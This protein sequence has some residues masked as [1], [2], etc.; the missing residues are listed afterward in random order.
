MASARQCLFCDSHNLTRE[1]IWPDWLVELF[2]KGNYSATQA[3]S[4]FGTLTRHAKDITH[5]ARFVCGD[6]NRGWMSEI[7]GIASEFLKPVIAHST[8]RDQ[9]VHAIVITGTAAS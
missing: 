5:K 3:H 4:E 8:H 7:E 6:C 9:S 1:H 2:P